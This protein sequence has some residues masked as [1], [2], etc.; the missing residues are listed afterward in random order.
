MNPRNRP[1]KTRCH[2]DKRHP[3]LQSGAS[4]CLSHKVFPDEF[5]PWQQLFQKFRCCSRTAKACFSVVSS[6]ECFCIFRATLKHTDFPWSYIPTSAEAG[7]ARSFVGRVLL[8]QHNCSKH[9]ICLCKCNACR[10]VYLRPCKMLVGNLPNPKHSVSK[11]TIRDGHAERFF[12]QNRRQIQW[13][14]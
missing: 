5:S 8:S 2:Q 4:F 1:K 13:V 3:K 14:D 12:N 9:C 7:K 10:P 6:L 11:D